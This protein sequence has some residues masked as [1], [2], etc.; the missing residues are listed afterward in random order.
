MI[1]IIQ[2]LSDESAPVLAVC[3]GTC[4]VLGCGHVEV[5]WVSVYV[6]LVDVAFAIGNEY[7]C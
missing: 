6:R 3:L 7:D 2:G 4:V 5:F 1:I